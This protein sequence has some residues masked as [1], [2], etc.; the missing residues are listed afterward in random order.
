MTILLQVL[1]LTLKYYL[2][3]S[4]SHPLDPLDVSEIDRIRSIVQQSHGHTYPNLSFH[5]VDLEEPKKED[6]LKWLSS[7]KK[8]NHS[9]PPPL[10]RGAKVVIRVRG[11]THELSIDLETNRVLSDHT[12][13][14]NG[15]PPLT[16]TELYR[17]SKLPLE[18][19]KFEESVLKRGLNISEVSCIPFTVGWY[20]EAVTKRALKVSCF[21]RGGTVNVFARPIEGVTILVDV[22]SMR[23][24]SYNDRFTIPLPKAKGSDYESSGIAP[25]STRCNRTASSGFTVKGREVR[26]ANWEFHLAFHARA[27]IIISTASIFDEGKSKFRRVLYRGHVSETFVPYMDPKEEWYFRTFMDIGEYGFG[28]AADSLQAGVD[29]PENA[30]YIDGY[31]VGADGHAQV[32]PRVI[33]VFERESSNVAWR[34]TEINVPGRVVALTGILEMKATAYTNQYQIN[35]NVYGILV[36]NNT[37]AVNHDHFLTYYLDVDIDGRANTFVKS[38][39]KTEKVAGAGPRSLRKI[40]WTVVKEIVKSESEGRMQLGLEAADLLVVNPGQRTR[41]GNQVGYRLIPGQ[42]I[43]SLLSDD[44]FPQIRASYTK[45]QMWVTAYNRTERW[46]GGFYADRSRGDDGLAI[47]TRRNREIENRDIVLWYSVGFHHIPYQ[48]DFPV[49]PTLHGGFE[50]RPSNFFER[51]PLLHQN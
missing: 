42:P 27:G 39:L 16:F 22:D 21:Y 6:V 44:D 25:N 37:V 5:Y 40:Y 15:F 31:V 36:A 14:G 45:Y 7:T 28:K 34:H 38:R 24:T 11:Q 13:T 17:A 18:Y 32:V 10:R 33:C 30:L 1:L 26:W 20:G 3:S 23:I 9:P 46:A 8:L 51:N 19:P 50:L 2:T 12:Y 47:W 35:E 4:Y 48:E 29:C 41:I 49:M 43:S